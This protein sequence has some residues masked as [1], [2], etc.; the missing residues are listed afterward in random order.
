MKN[1][2]VPRMIEVKL[3]DPLSGWVA[4]QHPQTT[5]KGCLAREQSLHLAY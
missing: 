3:L 2:V 4:K 5:L 1:S